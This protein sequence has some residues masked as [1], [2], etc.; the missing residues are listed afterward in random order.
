MFIA[1]WSNKI[2]K[3]R[4]SSMFHVNQHAAPTEL[5]LGRFLL[6]INIQLLRSFLSYAELR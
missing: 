4:R 3:L 2:S 1:H 5:D 6:T